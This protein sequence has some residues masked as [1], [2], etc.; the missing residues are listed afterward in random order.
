MEYLRLTIRNE[1]E[2]LRKTIDVLKEGK[3]AAFPTETFYALG[4]IY[5]NDDA[6]KRL[7]ELKRRPFEK[8]I[9]IIVGYKTQISSLA[10]NVPK[11]VEE[12]MDRY[13]PGP[14]TIVLDAQEGLN[15]YLTAG[16]GKIA[17]RV[18]GE[19]FALNLA[20]EAGFPITATSANPSGVPPAVDAQDVLKFF[21]E[22]I[23][24]IVDGGHTFGIEP[25]TIVEIVKGEVKTLRKGRIGKVTLG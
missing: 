20:R 1:S 19:S 21:G 23:D 9:P 5:D 11:E 8:A 7:Y 16:T 2:T 10:G 17:V 6:L 3:I 4:A 13:W 15:T 18:P 22:T 25:S 14:L 12:L 24:L